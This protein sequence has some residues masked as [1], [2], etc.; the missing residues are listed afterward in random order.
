MPTAR[1]TDRFI[2][3]ISCPADQALVDY[4]DE[5]LRSLTLRVNA[6][7]RK[8]FNLRYR[9]NGQRRRI[10]LGTF[11]DGAHQILLKEA[12]VKATS[13][14]ARIQVGDDPA[15][16]DVIEDDETLMRSSV[17][18][19]IE[20]YMARLERKGRRRSYLYD[21]KMR[22]KLHVSPI[23]GH[24]P[25]VDVNPSDMAKIFEPLEASG[26][27]TTHNR[28][29]T[30]VRPLFKLAEIPDPT[31]KIEK[32][33]EAAKEEWFSL[34]Q[35]AKLWIG[36]GE[37][38]A[39]VHPIT[40]D[41]IRLSMLTLKRAGECAGARFDEFDDSHWRIPAARMKGRREE[42]VPLSQATLKLIERI[43]SQPLRP[44][45]DGGFLFPSFAK[46]G[47][48]I[49]RTA[50]SRAFPR[51]RR[52]ITSL[53]SHAGTLHS[54]RHSGATILATNGVSPYIISGLLS[55]ALTAAGVSQ[56]TSRYNM[57]DLLDERGD[58][59]ETWGEMLTS[60]VKKEMKE[61]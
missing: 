54:L 26:K 34:T 60:A 16:N 43:K 7:G 3:S 46:P 48:H 53:K 47:F 20:Q 27:A 14:L 17:D 51:T 6:G 5:A 61:L 33:P 30:M 32:L 52:Q 57:Y 15:R 23:I 18:Q 36:L 8:V 49:Q 2:R 58:A 25:I 21:V 28:V 44:E 4:A 59:L 35:L 55:H 29:L 37:P 24:V 45:I 42:V 31:A 9:A 12:R 40:A 56:V 13:L 10:A 22:F 38:K 1:L 39:K 41:S 50:M 11:G 19:V